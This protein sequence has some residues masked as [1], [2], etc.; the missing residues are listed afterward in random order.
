MLLTSKGMWVLPLIE[1][2]L[3]LFLVDSAWT[4]TEDL[5]VY[6]PGPGAGA[7]VTRDF[8]D[9]FRLSPGRCGADPKDDA[10]MVF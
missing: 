2:E 6:A 7:V 8:V 3:E 4:P 10:G 1:N 9:K 5:V